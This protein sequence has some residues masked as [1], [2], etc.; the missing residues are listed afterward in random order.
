M[1][2][3]GI[4]KTSL[5]DGYGVNYVIF[6][7]GCPHECQGCQNPSTHDGSG[8]YELSLGELQTDIVNSKLITGVTF[9]GGEPVEQFREVYKLAKWAK[10]RGL[11]TTM[12]TGY[13]LS[14]FDDRIEFLQGMYSEYSSFPVYIGA[15]HRMSRRNF[16]CFDY[17]IDGRFEIAQKSL[18][19]PFRGSSNQRILQRGRDY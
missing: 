19:T 9:S 2:I 15:R 7:Q 6:V 4:R 12:Y 14:I 17:I 13:K 11:Q 8:G 3:A 10:K 1:R 16:D 18:D 5:F